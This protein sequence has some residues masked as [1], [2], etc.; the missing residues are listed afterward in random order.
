MRGYQ[1][2][3][4]RGGQRRRRRRRK[5]KKKG[6]RVIY[7]FPLGETIEVHGVRQSIYGTRLPC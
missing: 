3:I 1:V 6:E 7:R 5:K 4:L 2:S